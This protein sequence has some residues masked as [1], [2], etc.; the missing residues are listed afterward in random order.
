MGEHEATNLAS[1]AFGMH[2]SGRD[3]CVGGAEAS[4]LPTIPTASITR[5]KCLDEH[6][7]RKL[8]RFGREP[9]EESSGLPVDHV[10]GMVPEDP[11]KQA[12]PPKQTLLRGLLL[13]PPYKGDMQPRSKSG[14]WEKVRGMQAWA[15]SRLRGKKGSKVE[16]VP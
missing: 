12:R 11:P 9:S 5:V 1:R 4:A 14:M 8:L 16:S 10:R 6:E 15:A 13:L 2:K 3:D 7:F